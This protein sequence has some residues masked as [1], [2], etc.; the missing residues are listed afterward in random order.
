[1]YQQEISIEDCCNKGLQ[2]AYTEKNY[3]RS[4][5]YFFT[6]FSSGVE[7]T[8]CTVSCN[9]MKCGPQKKCAIR[10]GRPKCVCSILC[11]SSKI[12]KKLKLSSVVTSREIRSL[13]SEIYINSINQRRLTKTTL[14]LNSHSNNSN[15]GISSKIKRTLSS[16]TLITAHI[17]DTTI[18]PKTSGNVNISN[19]KHRHHDHDQI[20]HQNQKNN[21]RDKQR[22]HR[23]RNA[24]LSGNKTNSYNKINNRNNNS[25]NRH[26]DSN[27]IP[28]FST[29][30]KLKQNQQINKKKDGESVLHLQYYKNNNDFNI[31]EE[32]QKQQ[33]KQKQQPPEN[34]QIDSKFLEHEPDSYHENNLWVNSFS[35]QNMYISPFFLFFRL[36]WYVFI[37]VLFLK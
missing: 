16:S 34:L 24:L 10:N 29:L 2:F 17:F 32:Q 22:E 8:P 12:K 27:G 36:L 3:T 23:I 31:Q 30:R 35:L 15:R 20:F 13:S 37:F 25:N 9:K 5:I 19:K 33:N 11:K 28:S 18:K 1:M 14:T 7:C 26:Q 21:F 4:E 6:L